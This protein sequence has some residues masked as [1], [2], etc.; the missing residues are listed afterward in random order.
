MQSSDAII[1]SDIDISGHTSPSYTYPDDYPVIWQ[2]R[3]VYA[4]NNT[5]EGGAVNITESSSWFVA[6]RESTNSMGTY[7]DY[8][9]IQKPGYVAYA[10]PHPLRGETP[11][12]FPTDWPYRQL[13]T[14]SHTNIDD[15]LQ[16]FPLIIKFSHNADIGTNAQA[17][18]DDIRFSVNGVDLLPYHRVYFTIEGDTTASGM[19][20]VQIDLS[21]TADTNFYI[22]YGNG[23]AADASDP[24]LVYA[25]DD[26][27]YGCKLVQMGNDL[28]TSTTEDMTVYGNDGTKKAADE[29]I[30]A[31]G[32]L[33]K[34][35]HFDGTDDYINYGSAASLDNITPYTLEYLVY[36]DGW[37]SVDYNR[38][39]CKEGTTSNQQSVVVRN[40]L[41]SVNASHN[42]ATGGT[43][44]N[45]RTANDT[46]SLGAWT[47][48]AVTYN[49]TGD[50]TLHIFI[51]GVESSYAVTPTAMVGTIR[52]DSSNSLAIGNRLGGDRAFDGKIE[53][54]RFSSGVRSAAW[55]KF[56]SANML[57]ADNELTFSAEE[58]SYTL[59]VTKSGAGDGTITSIPSGINYG[60]DGTEDYLSDTV[61][62]LTATPD[63]TSTFTT[64]SG[65]V[66]GG[67]E[68]DN[69]VEITMSAAKGV[70]AEFAAPTMRTLTVTK[71]GA[72]TGTI[73]SN[74]AGIDYGADDTEDYTNGTVVY[75]T[76]N[77]D[78]GSAFTAWS[79]DV[80]AG[81]ETDN[82]VAI[83]MNAA[84]G[85]NAAFAVEATYYGEINIQVGGVD[86]TSGGT[87]YFGTVYIV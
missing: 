56:S 36:L 39:S 80:E 8:R 66:P 77:A 78:G 33:Y 4:W 79:G 70:D 60:T 75:L 55:L 30:Q 42:A 28:T 37:G 25:L 35:Q 34:C 29:P 72:G 24:T 64:W 23:G 20:V 68:T 44:A 13:I 59:T 19:F 17:D 83:T 82:P 12:S 38:L 41:H 15:G 22:Y 3:D 87:K 1:L 49:N 67:H 53:I 18:G 85:V 26:V 69:P 50:R 14:V 46:L 21:N 43:A 54:F 73:V 47:H 32:L 86:V 65:D 81:H 52:N 9:N 11:P 58:T 31:I 76:A 40:A 6:D 51:N 84:K 62:S 7:Y 27:G 45:S 63:G 48:I 16:D 71:S 61:V 2:P 10:Y 57:E 5:Y 74:P